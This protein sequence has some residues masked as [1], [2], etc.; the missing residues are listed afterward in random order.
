MSTGL[1]AQREVRLGADRPVAAT[2]SEG[3]W[4]CILHSGPVSLQGVRFRASL[5]GT[6]LC[7]CLLPSL[8][9]SLPGGSVEVGGAGDRGLEPS[10]FSLERLLSPLPGF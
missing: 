8:V 1:S 9:L 2:L 10:P 4:G 6:D 5:S 3:T 7:N